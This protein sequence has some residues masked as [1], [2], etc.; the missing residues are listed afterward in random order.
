MSIPRAI[1]IAVP[2]VSGLV[3]VGG[4]TWRHLVPG[5]LAATFVI[6]TGY[7]GAVLGVVGLLLEV[8]GF[9]LYFEGITRRMLE[10]IIQTVMMEHSFL[11]KMRKNELQDIR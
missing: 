4:V 5:S 7:F 6:H 11:S 8:E 2:I 9:R 3:I 10:S 1:R